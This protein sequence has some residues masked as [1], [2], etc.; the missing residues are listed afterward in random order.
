MHSTLI[1]PPVQ[2]AHQAIH[3]NFVQ[4]AQVNAEWG[5]VLAEVKNQFDPE[6]V[7]GFMDEVSL[8]AP[9]LQAIYASYLKEY[10]HV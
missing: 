2:P 9:S 3:A 7:I 5:I 10:G 6:I 1:T 8:E 4:H